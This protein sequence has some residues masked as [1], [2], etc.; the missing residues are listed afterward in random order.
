MICDIQQEYSEH[1]LQILA[2]QFE[3][4]Y[5][6]HL[7][8]DS[9]RIEELLEK[10]RTEILLIGEECEK[11]IFSQYDVEKRFILTGIPGRKEERGTIPLFRYQS[12]QE[13]VRTIRRNI[14]RSSK[15][16]KKEEQMLT[17]RTGCRQR[18]EGEHVEEKQGDWKI[19]DEPVIRGLVGIYS[20]VHR[21][22]KTKFAIRLGQKMARQVPVLYLNMEGYSGGAYYFKEETE[23]NLGDLF[24]FIKQDVRSV[25]AE[26]WISLLDMIVN[27]CIYEVIILDLGDAVNGLYDILRKCD[28]IYTPYICEG[29]AEAKLEQYENNLRAA[30]YEDILRNTVKR[31]VGKGNRQ[32]RWGSDHAKDRNAV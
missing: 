26:E 27:K 1:L 9:K 30:G 28:R 13:I 23:K 20:P 19:R 25:K 32:E 31:Q 8:H 21:I 14:N 12:A 17:D 5:Q 22:G 16:S 3:G 7:F 6:F 2:E 11:E 24:Y 18:Y 15:V 4:E 29:A 10:S